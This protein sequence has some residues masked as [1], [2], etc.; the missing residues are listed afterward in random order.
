LPTKATAGGRCSSFGSRAVF[1]MLLSCLAASRAA[2]IGPG[3]PALLLLLLLLLLLAMPTAAYRNQRPKAVRFSVRDQHA[4]SFIS[5]EVP[6]QSPTDD[7]AQL[8]RR[9][10][11]RSAGLSA[12]GCCWSRCH[13]QTSFLLR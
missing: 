10:L 8:F 7:L 12:F 6:T 11:S 1:Q 9:L 5:T 4:G 2:C 3:A 13:K